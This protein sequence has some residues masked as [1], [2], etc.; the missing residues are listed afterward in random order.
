MSGFDVLTRGDVLEQAL[1]ARDYLVACGVPAALAA[2]DPRLWGRR[3]VDHSRLAWLDLPFASRY[4]LDK[5]DDVVTEARF[6]G[7]DH[8]VL[9]GVGADALAAQAIME[10]HA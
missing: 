10:E 3:A 1:Q 4:L 5:V 9:V 6:S 2:K 7:L 8:V